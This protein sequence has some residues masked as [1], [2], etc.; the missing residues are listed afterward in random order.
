[1]YFAFKSEQVLSSR[2]SLLVGMRKQISFL[3][4]ANSYRG[5]SANFANA[6]LSGTPL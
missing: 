6:L 1:M 5:T 2:M 3:I 4:L